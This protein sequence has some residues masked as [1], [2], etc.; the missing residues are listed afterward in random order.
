VLADRQRLKQIVMNLVTN[1]I[2]YNRPGGSVDVGFRLTDQDRV[3]IAIR[4]TGLG[5]E[6]EKLNRIFD[7]FDRLG[8]DTTGIEGTGLGLTISRSL[9]EAMGGTLTVESTPGQG[10]TFWLTLP[11]SAAPS[12]ATVETELAPIP[13]EIAAAPAKQLV[14]YVE[15]NAPNRVLIERILEWRPGVEL[16]TATDGQS[17]LALARERCPSLVL[18]DLHLPDING[19][20]VLEA[21]RRDSRTASVPVVILSADA[22]PGQIERLLSAGAQQYLTK[23]IA[24]REL[25]EA[26]DSILEAA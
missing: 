2:K 26:V 24:V 22:S 9:V 11:A 18:L 21:L 23:P 16:M 17:G 15:D 5:I 3:Q 25:L 13:Q 20:D 7:P 4:D 6:P 1:A 14:L 10:S 8:A 19:S 12:T